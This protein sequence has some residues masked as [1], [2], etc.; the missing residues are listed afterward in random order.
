MAKFQGGAATETQQTGRQLSSPRTLLPSHFLLE[1]KR[2]A[3]WAFLG[4]PHLCPT[5]DGAFVQ[6]QRREEQRLK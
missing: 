5:L 6:L 2:R 4:G 3:Q 1:D